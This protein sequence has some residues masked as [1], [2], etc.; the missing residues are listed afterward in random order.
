[1]HDINPIHTL[2]APSTEPWSA[3]E[4][5]TEPTATC[6]ISER[7]WPKLRRRLKELDS[8][9]LLRDL[10]RHG[11]PLLWSVD[12]AWLSG[13]QPA[14]LETDAPDVAEMAR[15]AW[16]LLA[17][18]SRPKPIRALTEQWLA[19][20]CSIK[21]ATVLP[22]LALAYH[23]PRLAYVLPKDVLSRVVEQL[24]T[25]ARQAG[26]AP[27]QSWLAQLLSVELPIVLGHYLRKVPACQ[28]AATLAKNALELSLQSVTDE[29]GMPRAELLD[30]F[31]PLLASWARALHL[32]NRRDPSP[33]DS[34]ERI[35]EQYV[36]A[37]EQAL[38]L[39]RRDTTQAFDP[40]AAEP[41]SAAWLVDA[42]KISGNARLAT[43]AKRVLKGSTT[44]PSEA[45][46]SS[47]HGELSRLAVLRTDW[48]DAA[49]RLALAFDQRQL[50]IELDTG[51]DLVLA[52]TCTPRVTFNGE[53]VAPV[54]QWS[55]A[56]WISKPQVDYLE[57]H[58]EFEQ[59]VRL[60]RQFALA[61]DDGFLFVADVITAAEPGAITARSGWPLVPGVDFTPAQDNC[62]GL[63]MQEKPIARV[64]PLAMP[65]WRSQPSAAGLDASDEG[66][67]LTHQAA[68]ARAL[69]L[70]MVIDLDRSRLDKKFTWR[71][72]TVAEDHE[73]V[74]ADMAVGYRLQL[75]A[76]QWLIYR[77]L[78]H[79]SPRSLLGHHLIS[80]FLLGRVTKKGQIKRLVEVE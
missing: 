18:K 29:T 53:Q 76:H 57:L 72:L 68:N 49:S 41:R 78:Q 33:D 35:R 13:G 26:Q 51:R 16:D 9:K 60:E 46:S 36:L 44:P 77:S 20:E 66:F 12:A 50:R 17:G 14:Q 34:L 74:P 69:Y 25:L 55:E 32:L 45:P 71:R 7:D 52:G 62:E 6:T 58:L 22:A 73:P 23:L 39:T 24:I 31:R 3:S 65:E 1:M 21:A 37:V 47:G 40:V 75:G 70:P 59:G 56:C 10:T 5:A 67:A 28:Q 19:Q 79:K 64:F 2:D 43:L 11:S 8:A 61:R 27:R 42:A 48:S 30:L 54:S 38:R 4:P 15:D 80:E 63:L